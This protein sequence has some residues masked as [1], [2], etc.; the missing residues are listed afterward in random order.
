LCNSIP[1]FDG[2]NDTILNIYRKESGDRSF[3]ERSSMGHLDL[4]RAREG[5]LAGGFF[6]LFAPNSL[7]KQTPTDPAPVPDRPLAEAVDPEFAQ[8]F[9]MGIAG[10]LLQLEAESGGK[11][12]IVR[13]T[14]ELETCFEDGVLA[15]VMH[16]EGAEAI[17][18]D[19]ERLYL[20]HAAGLRSLGITW[21][22]PNIFATGVPFRFPASPDIGPGLTEAGQRLVKTCN[23]LGIL[24][25]VS[26]LN[27]QGFW[28][29][30]ELS[31]AP[32][33]AT[34]SNAHAICPSSRNLMDRQL[35]AIG[36]SGGVVGV[37]FHVSFLRKD[38]WRKADTP[39]AQIVEH[40]RYI[41]DRIGV[42][43]VAFGSDFDGATMPDELKD[44]TGLPKLM[45]ALAAAGFDD[46][47]LEKIAYKNWV[48][49]FRETWKN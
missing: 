28:D 40:A 49:I 6:A 10:N 3:F 16:I 12:K 24:V 47:A 20:L 27:E 19:L 36:A 18:T 11:L 38:G 9:T 2:H 14:A 7:E 44:A 23:R 1:I 31:Q 48:R 25:D 30:A 42:D 13:K 22:R 41:A 46:Q 29:V 35:D 15:V 33:V 17:D 32:L 21:S 45:A 37:N 5:G 8:S 26:H 4:P 39:L 34:H 43:H